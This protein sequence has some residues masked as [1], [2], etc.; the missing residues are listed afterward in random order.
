LWRFNTRS[1]YD[2]VNRYIQAK[3]FYATLPHKLDQAE[4]EWH[5]TQPIE[6]D[7]WETKET[8]T[9]GEDGWSISTS[10]KPLQ[11]ND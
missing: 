1:D 6:E 7:P 9:F 4:E 5:T 2:R 8:G 3:K 10:Y 11:D